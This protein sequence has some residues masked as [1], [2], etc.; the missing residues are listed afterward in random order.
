MVHVCSKTVQK[1]THKRSVSTGKDN[2]QLLSR[3]PLTK[4]LVRR[5]KDHKQNAQH[6]YYVNTDIPTFTARRKKQIVYIN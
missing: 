5:M 6:V 4:P 2:K 3:L 1:Y